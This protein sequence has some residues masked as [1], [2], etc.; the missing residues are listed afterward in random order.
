[1]ELP[2]GILSEAVFKTQLIAGIDEV[3]DPDVISMDQTTIP[4]G[5][6]GQKG[7]FENPSRLAP[8][9]ILVFW[10]KTQF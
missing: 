6:L 9:H 3:S 2:G 7:F 10:G 1:M 8:G 5:V 4:I